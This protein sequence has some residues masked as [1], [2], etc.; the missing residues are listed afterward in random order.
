MPLKLSDLTEIDRFILAELPR[1]PNDIAKVT[2]ERF[3]I[4]RQGVSRHLRRLVSLGVLTATG[5]TRQRQYGF[6]TLGKT[7]V[8]LSITPEL[9]E[10]RVWTEHVAPLLVG[11]PENV[12][13]ICRY[14]VTEI[15]NNAIDHS[16][17]KGLGVIVEFQA[18]EIQIMVLDQGI[19]IFRKIKE[20]CGLEDERH[21][22][23][24][25]SKGKL[26]TDPDRHT[27]EGIFFTSRMFDSFGILS[28]ALWVG[29]SRTTGDWL[30]EDRDRPQ[31]G[32]SV[33]MGIG[34][35]SPHTTTEVFDHYATEQEDYA[36]SRTHVVVALAQQCQGGEKLVSRSQARRVMARLERFKE[37]ALDFRGV[38]D[39]GPAFADE[40]FRVFANEN[41]EVR[42]TPVEA[43]E[44]VMKMIRRAIA[45][46]QQGADR[47][48][49]PDSSG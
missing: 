30:L 15:V 28:G 41:P 27:G 46:R 32:T 11:I 9:H 38:E 26:T 16:D 36:F 23:L 3:G 5:A 17:S 6:A 35:F 20:A 12:L 24:E 40:I 21:A 37:V 49:S 33:H 47:K 31:P 25:L 8:W 2:A 1:H 39:I 22:I 44:S 13:D 4:T 29:C 19:G 45:N 18:K 48:G 42:L 10:D 14:G 7:G 34:P 43:N